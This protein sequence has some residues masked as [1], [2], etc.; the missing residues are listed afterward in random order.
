[1]H[2]HPV[3]LE[4]HGVLDEDGIGFCLIQVAGQGLDVGFHPDELSRILVQRPEL[5]LYIC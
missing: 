2:N 1:M 4:R 3:R 5:E